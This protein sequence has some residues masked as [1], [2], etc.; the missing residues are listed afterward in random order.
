MT[1]T[2]PCSLVETLEARLPLRR[3]LVAGREVNLQPCRCFAV[4]LE[5]LLQ[6]A[7]A[8]LQPCRDLPSLLEVCLQSRRGLVKLSEARLLYRREIVTV[9]EACLSG[10]EFHLQELEERLL[11]P[12]NRGFADGSVS[13][14]SCR[15]KAVVSVLPEIKPD[16]ALTCTPFLHA[17]APAFLGFR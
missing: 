3:H 15:R 5:A 7:E 17:Y 10:L 13:A 4:L 8:R 9:L 2:H 1:L 16:H 11:E 6:R 14:R 12:Q